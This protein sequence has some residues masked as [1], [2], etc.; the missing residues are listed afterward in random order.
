MTSM[1]R[2]TQTLDHLRAQPYS[3]CDGRFAARVRRLV[4]RSHHARELVVF[5]PGD[6]A[7]VIH[8]LASLGKTT[9]RLTRQP[10]LMPTIKSLLGPCADEQAAHSVLSHLLA[11]GKVAIDDKGAVRYDL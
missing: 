7:A 9:S 11:S 3:P 4:G 10:R 6:V 8:V 1:S 2:D 5:V